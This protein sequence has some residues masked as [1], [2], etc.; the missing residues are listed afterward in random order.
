MDEVYRRLAARLDALP[1]GF[2]RTPGGVELRILQ[3]IFSPEDAAL[4]ARLMP[5]PESVAELARRLRL[6]AEELGPR[7]EGMATR[8]QILAARRDGQPVY[9][10]APFVVGIYEFQLGRMDAELA[11]LF[12][13]YAPTLVR[14]LGGS[15]PA[16]AR[17]VPVNAR[18]EA[19]AE[20][21]R[22]ENVRELLSRA[23]SF[24]L[25]ECICRKEQ[26]LIGKPCSHTLETCLAFSP[27]AEGEGGTLPE[28]FGRSI[29]HA[30]ALAVLD[31]AEQEGL[32]HCT[33]NVQRQHMFVCNCCSCCCGFLRG[34]KEFGAPHLLLRSNFVAAVDAQACAACGD[35]LDRCPMEALRLEGDGC[36]V[37]GARC[38]GCGVCTVD[39]PT[40]AIS[41]A[42]RPPAERDQPP[43]TL[44]AW[45][46]QRALHRS[47]PLRTAAQV[48]GMALAAL[49]GKVTG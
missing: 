27:A 33:Y 30:E 8:G 42:P 25:M 24:R 47:G 46:L 11:A 35:C 22:H 21:L 28:G 44:A 2:P 26:A 45:A 43:A 29:S 13:E 17:V 19:R 34:L 37:D 23:R 9:M 10:L 48:G 18:I 14:E 3:K 12:E 31:R 40:D 7:L 32:V 4:A 49:R 41:L 38:L 6:E 5:M 36:L 15:R 16:L 20:V 1:H 39:C